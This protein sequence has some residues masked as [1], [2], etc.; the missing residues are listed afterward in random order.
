MAGYK[1]MIRIPLS[2]FEN[3]NGQ[4]SNGKMD[5]RQ[6]TQLWLVFISRAIRRTAT[7]CWIRSACV[8]NFSTSGQGEIS[9]LDVLEMSG[10]RDAEKDDDKPNGGA[11]TGDAALPACA[12]AAPS[13]GG[14]RGGLHPFP[15][16]QKVSGSSGK[17]GR[18]Q[19]RSG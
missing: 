2:Q 12:G 7:S 10:S 1:G 14:F 11:D 6:V 16:A 18:S 19:R 17:S 13:G 4:D 9:V 8:G 5:L 3:I 15:E